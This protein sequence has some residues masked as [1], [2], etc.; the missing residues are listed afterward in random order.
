M[1]TRQKKTIL[2]KDTGPTEQT[3]KFYELF[4][5]SLRSEGGENDIQVVTVA[6][7]EIYG[8][9][10]VVH[11]LPS[12]CRLKKQKRSLSHDRVE[13]KNSDNR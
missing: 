8:R 6:D 9:G 2:L 12:T 11:V 3:R 10:V 4:R 1:M 7:M 13:P 5:E